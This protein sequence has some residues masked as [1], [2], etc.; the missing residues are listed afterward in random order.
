MTLH[1]IKP[2]AA[3]LCAVCLFLLSACAMPSENEDTTPSPSLNKDTRMDLLGTVITLSTYE[4]VEQQ[5]FDDAFSIVADIESRMSTNLPDSEISHINQNAGQDFIPVSDDTRALIEAGIAFSDLS[6]GA[7][8][9]TVG[10][11]MELW[12]VDGEFSVRPNDDEIADRLHLLN[13]QEIVL[14]ADGVLLNQPGMML[15]LGGIAKGYACDT[16]LD[17]FKAQ[18]V[19]CALLDF[20]GNI[21][22]HGIK[23][24]GTPWKIGVQLPFIGESGV[25]CAVEAQDASVVTSGGYERYF[26]QDGSVYH[27]ILDPKTGYPVYNGLLSVTIIDGSST[28]ADALSTSCFVLGLEAGY[29]LLESL[30]DSEGI[31]ITD[32]NEIYLTSGLHGRVSLIDSRFRMIETAPV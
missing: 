17:Y 16:V 30:P 21:Y 7:F 9:I 8:D 20:G 13:Y 3:V 18:N 32:K 12:K 29:A 19:S 24:D 31:F 4:D 1:K 6:G 25:V 2:I 14:F 22:A 26:E 5:V 27:H 15:D 10:P 23:P 28:R 11:V